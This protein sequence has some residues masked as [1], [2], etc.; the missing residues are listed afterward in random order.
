MS[1]NHAEAQGGVELVRTWTAHL[2]GTG[3][4]MELCPDISCRAVFN[5]DRGGVDSRSAGNSWFS[6]GHHFALVASFSRDS[7]NLHQPC[8]KSGYPEDA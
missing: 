2:G 5:R 1:V 7:S 8:S 4:P 6:G 3:Q